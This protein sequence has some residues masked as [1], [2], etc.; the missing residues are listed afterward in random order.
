M[1]REIIDLA[2]N[3]TAFVTIQPK[4][5]LTMT[6]PPVDPSPSQHN[7][8]RATDLAALPSDLIELWKEYPD[9]L[10]DPV[11]DVTRAT[12]A[13]FMSWADSLFGSEHPIATTVKYLATVGEY[14]QSQFP[15]N[16]RLTY[17]DA[18]EYA[19]MLRSLIRSWLKN[20]VG[21]SDRQT[22]RAR[23]ASGRKAN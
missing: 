9:N 6:G 11:R 23:S 22:P 12:I 5:G 19:V 13:D 15:Q 21:L 10:D 7:Q 8:Q 17:R 14:G 4:S 1:Q 3:F 18:L 16:K 2:V 20:E